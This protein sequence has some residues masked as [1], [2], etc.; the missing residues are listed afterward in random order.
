MP[1]VLVIELNP[2]LNTTWDFLKKYGK[3][4]FRIAEKFRPRSK[5]MLTVNLRELMASVWTCEV[6][7][8]TMLTMN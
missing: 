2:F 1:E 8:A 5:T 3:F 4:R 7:S 6:N